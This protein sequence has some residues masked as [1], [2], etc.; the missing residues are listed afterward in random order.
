MRTVLLPAAESALRHKTALINP[1]PSPQ[2]LVLRNKN[3]SRAPSA[4]ARQLAGLGG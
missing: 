1:S 4:R 2:P 3:Y